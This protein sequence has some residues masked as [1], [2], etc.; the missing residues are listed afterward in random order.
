MEKNYSVQELFFSWHNPKEKDES[1]VRVCTAPRRRPT[2]D[3]RKGMDWW[4]RVDNIWASNSLFSK[5]NYCS[6]IQF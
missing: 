6:K 5:L 1:E 3:S 4:E 2:F